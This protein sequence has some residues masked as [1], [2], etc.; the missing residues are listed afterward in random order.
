MNHKIIQLEDE[1]KL[2]KSNGSSLEF[3][4][5]VEARY[6]FYTPIKIG[7][8]IFD[9]RWQQLMVT[10]R[11][12]GIP[13]SRHDESLEKH[14]LLSYTVAQAVR[15]WFVALADAEVGKLCVETRLIKHE[16]HCTSKVEAVGFVSDE[17]C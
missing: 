3:G 8:Q 14:G 11:D 2:V 12:F 10:K 6:N 4:Y 15:W 5:T 13:T 9:N 17:N 7:V 1:Y 16:L